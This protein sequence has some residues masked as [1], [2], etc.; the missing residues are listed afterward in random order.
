VRQLAADR[1]DFVKVYFNSV[2]PDVLAAITDEAH[3]LKLK[4]IGHLP[5]GMHQTIALESGMDGIEHGLDLRAASP[6]ALDQFT[7]EATARRGTTL[8]LDQVEASARRLWLIDR[9]ETEAVHKHMAKRDMWVTPTLVVMSRV[10]VEI[11]TGKDFAADPRRR[12]FAP[13]VWD[14]WDV[15]LGVRQPS[16]GRLQD[17]RTQSVKST[18]EAVAA[19][20]KAGV[21]MLVGTDCGVANNYVLPGWSMH[22]EMD[23]LVTAGLKPVD[24]LRMATVNAA[25]WRDRLQHEG[26]VEAGKQADFVILR[27]NPLEDIRS[28]R[29]VDG[30]VLRGRYLSASDLNSLLEGV[31]ERHAAAWARRAAPGK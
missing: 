16:T 24:V 30:L 28:A 1:V 27:A 21:P 7:K 26:T 25:R 3:R 23:A 19:A 22:E 12:Y 17:L 31:A 29:Q 20:H 18:A 14:S 13:E 4:V 15:K 5:S 10:W 11:G 6:A 2:K 8:A 9:Q